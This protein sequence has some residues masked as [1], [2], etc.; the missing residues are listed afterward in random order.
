MSGK[1]TT[2]KMNSNL[3][4]FANPYEEGAG[5]SAEALNPDFISMPGKGE[6]RTQDEPQLLQCWLKD[7][8]EY[9]ASSSAIG[10]TEAGKV[11]RLLARPGFTQQAGLQLQEALI[12]HIQQAD[13]GRVT[14]LKQRIVNRIHA[15]PE[16]FIQ[17]CFGSDRAQ[18]Y[19]SSISS[20]YTTR[21]RL[22][23]IDRESEEGVQAWLALYNLID[24]ALVDGEKL[25]K[26]MRSALRKPGTTEQEDEAMI[27]QHLDRF[28]KGR[29][30]NYTFH[31]MA[32][33][34][35]LYEMLLD[36]KHPK[37]FVE[38]LL[39]QLIAR[40][41]VDDELGNRASEDASGVVDILRLR[42][43]TQEVFVALCDNT[44]PEVAHQLISKIY[45]ILLHLR[46]DDKS[47]D[48]LQQLIADYKA[49]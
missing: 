24:Q 30:G 1:L 19:L 37:R 5:S 3:I 16:F 25:Q 10:C 4:H 18:S 7:S 32:G 15:Y 33:A 22:E 8:L 41:N 27:A 44:A 14:Q 21:Q 39:Q 38:L 28:F 35:G 36:A 34:R 42:T 6:Y 43:L 2:K 40:P 23:Q 29:A 26:Q 48:V 17:T 46:E 11:S 9:M 49:A 13:A 20:A 47:V 45:R 12:R 31:M